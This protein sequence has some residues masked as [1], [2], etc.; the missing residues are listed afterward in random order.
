MCGLDDPPLFEP[1]YYVSLRAANPLFDE[2]PCASPK[3]TLADSPETPACPAFPQSPSLTGLLKSPPGRAVG[4]SLDLFDFL[5]ESANPQTPS[6]TDLLLDPVFD[7]VPEDQRGTVERCDQDDLL[8][9]A[10][11][12]DMEYTL[13]SMSPGTLRSLNLVNMNPRVMPGMYFHRT[14]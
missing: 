2:S 7:P 11:P 9:F 10:T 14:C 1:Q 5:S 3:K 12:A 4:E 6:L 13:D 8:D